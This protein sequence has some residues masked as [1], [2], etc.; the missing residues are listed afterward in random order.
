[1]AD[2]PTDISLNAPQTRGGLFQKGGRGGPGR[3]AVPSLYTALTP[4]GFAVQAALATGIVEPRLIP[5]GLSDE[6]KALALKNIQAA[7]AAGDIDPELRGKYAEVMICRTHGRPQEQ[8]EVTGADGGPIERMVI[9]VRRAPAEKAV[10]GVT[11]KKALASRD[12]E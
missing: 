12:A 1:M 7:A 2:V 5:E 3:P 10:E 8:I 4:V 9:E 11:V 6:Q